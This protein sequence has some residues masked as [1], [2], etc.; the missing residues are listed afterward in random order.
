MKLPIRIEYNGDVIED[1]E[2]CE[3]SG[4]D[5]AEVKKIGQNGDSYSAF[6]AFAVCCTKSLGDLEDK[7]QIRE[8]YKTATFDTVYAVALQGMALTRGVTEIEGRYLCK[9]GNIIEHIGEYADPLPEYE[10]VDNTDITLGINKVEISNKKTG[11]L[12]MSVES[13]GMR[14][15]T[16]EDSI[17]A[18]R[19]FPDDDSE[20]QFEIYKNCLKSV[21]GN[22]FTDKDKASF[23]DLIFKKMKLSDL[24]RLSSVLV[25][26]FGKTECVCMKCKRR[27]TTSL[28]LTNFFDLEAE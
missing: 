8:A 13:I 25:Q 16:V 12:L 5:I 1:A 24:N 11:E 23:G 21:D 28:D 17:R 6:L 20:M 4:A 18:F 27:W 7:A 3:M 9:C 15:P 19:K 10:S 22:E 26:D 2:L 14:R